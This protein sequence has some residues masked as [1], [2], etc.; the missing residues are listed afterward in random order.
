MQ[1]SVIS[2]SVRKEFV[3]ENAVCTMDT[4]VAPDWIDYNGHMTEWR[5]YQLLADGVEQ[6]LTM[7]GCTESYRARGY[8]FFS[9]EGHLRNLRECRVAAHVKVFAQFIAYDAKRVHLY[10]YMLDVERNIVI[11]TGEHVLLH[12]DTEVRRA[13]PMPGFMAECLDLAW[14]RWSS[15]VRPEGL[16][17]TL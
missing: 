2:A 16:I 4:I 10:Q 8:S 14:K 7:I 15:N 5:Y 17:R 12:V 3:P 6:F 13:A 11:A 1:S 9:V